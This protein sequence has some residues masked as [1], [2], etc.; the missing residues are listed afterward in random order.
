MTSVRRWLARAFDGL[1]PTAILVVCG[2]LLVTTM[3][4]L[5]NRV[6]V[7]FRDGQVSEW[8]L[9]GGSRMLVDL[10]MAA[11]AVVVIV[12]AMNLG[13]RSGW[14]R[15]AVLTVSVIVASVGC[16]FASTEAWIVL[17]EDPA[18]M[19]SYFSSRGL[20]RDSLNYGFRCATLTIIAEFYLRETRSI[21]AM[22]QAEVDRLTLDR[23][24]AA[25]R[26]QVLR[27]QIEPH[28]LF[29]TLANVRRLYQTDLAGGR[30]MLEHLMR[31]LE[32][33]LPRMRDETSRLERE[34]ALIESYLNVQKIRMGRRLTFAIDIPEAL[35]PVTVPSMMLLTLVENAIK[36]GLNPQLD[37]GSIDVVAR[38]TG[39]ELVLT[40]ADSGRGF[41]DETTGGGTGLAN[42]RARLSAMYGTAASLD[43]QNNEPTGI[44]ATL[45]MPVCPEPA[46][47]AT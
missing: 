41:G 45:V 14:P 2:L 23:E 40:V 39:D 20:V 5:V 1:T 34:R 3:G 32:V 25:A 42:I 36:H 11:L 44:V 27:A 26:L 33:A 21:E 12:P 18:E 38:I 28:F 29:N 22:H 46:S 43:L 15:Y 35:N 13:P 31:Y 47:A 16:A 10:A 30:L 19:W 37:G 8:L 9:G 24:M 7:V 17:G 4:G 6:F